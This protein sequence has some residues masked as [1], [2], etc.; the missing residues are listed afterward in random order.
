MRHIALLTLLLTLVPAAG[1]SA[2]QVTAMEICGREGCAPL[3]RAE[4]QGFHEGTSYLGSYLSGDQGAVRWY[5][6]AMT[7]GDGEQSFGQARFAYSPER[8]ALVPT[9]AVPAV[10]WQRVS[11]DGAEVLDLA[12]GELTPF[13]P[14]RFGPAVRK[15]ATAN[16]DDGGL[17]LMAGVPALAL[18]LG[19]GLV[20]ARR[21]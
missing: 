19:A 14:R 16:E 3:E 12:A 10:P 18:L 17:P 6:V 11:A 2:K 21:R 7:L 15:P 1:V 9:D 20:I 4:A 5:R 13:A 8:R